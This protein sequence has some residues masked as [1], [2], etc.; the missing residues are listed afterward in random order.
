[1]SL[2]QTFTQLK[3]MSSTQPC[4]AFEKRNDTLRLLKTMVR[5]QGE[6]LADAV[7]KD[8]TH[9]SRQETLFLEI[10][11]AVSAIDYCRSNLKAWMK[12][13]KRR[14][15]LYLKPAKA[16]ISPQ[17]LGVVGIIVPWNYPVYLAIVPLAYALAAGNRVMIKCSELTPETGS[18]LR[19]V[20][21]KAQL[22][23][24]VVIVNGDSQCAEE[25]SALPFDHLLF[26]GSTEVGKA[27]MKTASA[28]LT[29]ITL[30]LGGKS[31]VVIAEDCAL[32]NW[33]RIFIGKLYNAGQT[34]IAP[35]YCLI[36]RKFEHE[37][38]QQFSDFVHKRFPN[39]M[40]NND[41]TAII[42]TKHH[43]RLQELVEDA[44]SKGARIVAFG[45]R[46]ARSQKF[47][48]T[49][50][51]N[52]TNA[53]RVMQEE[54]FGPLL[55]IFFTDN[56]QQAMQLIKQR[57]AP[58]ALY[59]FGKN[60]EEINFLQYNTMSGSL[61][62]NDTVVQIAVNDLPFGGVGDS[63]IGAYHGKEGFDL[64]SHNKALF[65]QQ[66]YSL[67]SWFYPPYGRLIS[68]YLTYFSKIKRKDS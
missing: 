17:P 1:M 68:W 35:D 56:F 23:A 4:I 43:Q 38:E 62:I 45:E 51:F 11:P 46:E 24:F 28:H 31:P 16:Y 25:F 20:I 27:I 66:K 41:Y 10:A 44:Q 5:E 9:R 36:P 33:Q 52:A 13:Q 48:I 53:M 60:K 65:Y 55:P 15:P 64:F 22:D 39:C 58:L 7:N 6:A 26:T 3:K 34:C 30:E 57:P 59:Y 61:V 54:V 47:P 2:L 12:P 14:V 19:K 18:L 40:D 49:L 67:A 37:F 29:P 42:S 21:K 50:I 8:F 32:K 63:G